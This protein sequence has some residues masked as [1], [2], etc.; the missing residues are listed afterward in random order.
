MCKWRT[1]FILLGLLL[2]VGG[3]ILSP[4]AAFI[5]AENWQ[6]GLALCILAFGVGGM[7]CRPP[8]VI[9]GRRSWG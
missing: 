6:A 9:R 1:P 8:S 7:G 4:Y 5:L 2:C 3:A